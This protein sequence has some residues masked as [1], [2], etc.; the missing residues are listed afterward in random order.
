MSYIV[1]KE[2]VLREYIQEVLVK[3]GIEVEGAKII[4]D[5]LVEADLR[6][7]DTHGVVRLAVYYLKRIKKDL[8]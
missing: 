5:T 8:S 2:K 7:I 4:A 6:G 1:V 3:A